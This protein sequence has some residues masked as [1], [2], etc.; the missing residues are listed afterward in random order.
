M[1]SEGIFGISYSVLITSLS[2]GILTWIFF[3]KIQFFAKHFIANLSWQVFSLI[4]IISSLFYGRIPTNRRFFSIGVKLANKYLIGTKY[5]VRGQQILEDDFACVIVSNHQSSL[6]GNFMVHLGNYKGSTVIL[7]KSLLYASGLLGLAFYC[8]GSIFVDR[9]NPERAKESLNNA[10]DK[11]IKEKLKP[12]FYPEGTRHMG[13][14]ML[15][16]KKGA[17]VMAIN[18]QIPI[19]PVVASSYRHFYDKKKKIFKKGSVIVTCLPPIPTKG[20]TL[21]DVND[22]IHKVRSVMQD[23]INRTTEEVESL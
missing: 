8:S 15:P 12:Q 5:I 7:K 17:F 16:F 4:P 3:D 13:E 10:L 9:K 6:D 19:L 22:L 18:G 23:T 1:E 11:V 2:V 21:N 20:L 14:E